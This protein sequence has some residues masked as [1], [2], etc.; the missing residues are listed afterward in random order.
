MDRPR[1]GSRIP[2]GAGRGQEPAETLRRLDRRRAQ[3]GQDNEVIG[4]MRVVDLLSRCPAW[5]RSERASVD[6]ASQHLREPPGARPRRQP[7][8]RSRARVRRVTDP[9]TPAVPATPA[10]GPADRPGRPH[11]GRQGHRRR[12][13]PQEPPRG[14]DLGLRHDPRAPPGRG[15]TVGTTGSSPRRSSTTSSRAASCWSGPWS[16]RA[17]ATARSAGPWWRRS[18]GTARAARD[19]PAGCTPGPG[20][21]ARGVLRVPGP[22]SWRSWSAGSSAA[23]PRR[24]R[25]RARR[26]DRAGGAGGRVG[27]RRDG[28]QHRSSRRQRRVVAMMT[29][30][31][32]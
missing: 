15:C 22:P 32:S 28:R 13:H 23:A 18:R 17:P 25:S 6:G 1:Q 21:D 24:P 12:R 3:A 29:N 19:R 7:D 9:A 14:V 27:V 11:G 4:K 5:A 26:K 31:R 16:T 30:P 2:S 20:V 10:A 8:R